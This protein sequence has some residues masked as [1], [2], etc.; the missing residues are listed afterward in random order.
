MAILQ[1]SLTAE[2][3]PLPYPA[4]FERRQPDH[5]E[6]DRQSG[7]YWTVVRTAPRKEHHVQCQLRDL[8]VQSYL[9]LL[10]T[11]KKYRRQGQRLTEPFFPGYLFVLVDRGPAL[12]ALRQVKGFVS[13]VSFDGQPARLDPALLAE[14]RRRENGRGYICVRPPKLELVPQQPLEIV[15]GPFSGHRALFVRYLN[16]EERVCVL[17][18]ILKK[19]A[20]VELPLSYVT[21]PSGSPRRPANARC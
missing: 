18:D 12:Y 10:K 7:A 13:V 16:A 17:L 5:A 21:V 3:Y 20:I 9:P 11:F 14:L 6:P 15:D 1:N 19:Q 2:A 8:R 4:G